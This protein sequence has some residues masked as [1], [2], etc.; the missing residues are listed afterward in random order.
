MRQKIQSKQ[1]KKTVSNI[2]EFFLENVIPVL[3][4]LQGSNLFLFRMLYFLCKNNKRRESLRII[5]V[6]SLSYLE[7][8]NVVSA[9]RSLSPFKPVTY[10]AFR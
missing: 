5:V 4:L 2:L 7:L 6:L 10:F 8:L 1:P 9:F 3:K